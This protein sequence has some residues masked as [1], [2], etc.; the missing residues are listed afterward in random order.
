MWD[1]ALERE[2]ETMTREVLS[3]YLALAA[4]ALPA[5]VGLWLAARTWRRG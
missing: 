4:L 5:A 1:G 3:L 2:N